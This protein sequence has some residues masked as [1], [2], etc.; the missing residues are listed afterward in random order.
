MSARGDLL[1][2][3]RAWLKA[4]Q[5]TPLTDAQVILADE[6]EA[7]PPLPYL[8]VRLIAYDIKVGDDERR[9]GLDGGGL[10][11]ASIRG[12]RRATCTVQAF[13]DTATDWVTEAVI[14]LRQESIRA[15]LFA[16]GVAVTPLNGQSNITAVLADQSELRATQD[17]DLAYTYESTES[18]EIE[19]ATV[20]FTNE[21]DDRTQITTITL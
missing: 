11:V 5:A 20:V 7:R 9:T 18:G 13:G 10:P 4:A 12:Q 6:N 15:I 2:A 3:V 19:L 8:A 1:Q 17:F 21:F 14:S 16:S